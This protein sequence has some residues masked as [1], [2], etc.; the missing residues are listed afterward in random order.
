MAEYSVPVRNYRWSHQNILVRSPVLD[1]TSAL[2]TVIVQPLEGI[3][4][5]E[6][7]VL[8][9]ADLRDDTSNDIY[10]AEAHGVIVLPELLTDKSP[11]WVPIHSHSYACKEKE[12]YVVNLTTLEASKIPIAHICW[13]PGYRAPDDMLYTIIGAPRKFLRK[14]RVLALVQGLGFPKRVKQVLLDPDLLASYD[15]ISDDQKKRLFDIQLIHL[16]TRCGPPSIPLS[17]GY[18]VFCSPDRIG[19]DRLSLEEILLE[20]LEVPRRTRSV[21]SS[22]SSPGSSSDDELIFDK[23]AYLPLVEAPKDGLADVEDLCGDTERELG[24]IL[25]S[26]DFEPSFFDSPSP[27]S[28]SESEPSEQS[29]TEDLENHNGMERLCLPSSSISAKTVEELAWGSYVDFERYSSPEPKDM[30]F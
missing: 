22:Q 17:N 24:D 8:N 19:N 29:A 18:R 1:L 21:C 16:R 7:R 25:P 30:E 9:T 23:P 10:K 28:L 27:T 3:N 26:M 6:P 2:P 20:D 11:V 13:V 4:K 12:V 5:Q 14:T 15:K